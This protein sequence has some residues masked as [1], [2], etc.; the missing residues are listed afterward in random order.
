MRMLGQQ[1]CVFV[2]RTA[3]RTRQPPPAVTTSTCDAAA[4]EKIAGLKMAPSDPCATNLGGSY[5]DSP[6]AS[7]ITLG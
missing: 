5:T 4:L 6:V 1:S 7:A 3:L 2:A